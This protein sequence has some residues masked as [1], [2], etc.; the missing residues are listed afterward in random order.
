[1]V[2]V[3]APVLTGRALQPMIA[4]LPTLKLTVPADGATVAGLVAATVAVNVT[5]WCQSAVASFEPTVV[6]V[7]AL[8]TVWVR[9]VVDVLPVRFVLPE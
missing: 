6:V 2:Q 5:D 8:L 7:C 4:V 3:A 9:G 1:M